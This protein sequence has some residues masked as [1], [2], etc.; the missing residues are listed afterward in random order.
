M[1]AFRTSILL[2]LALAL[3]GCGF[4]PMYATQGDG[5]GLVAE[6]STIEVSPIAERVGQVVRNGLMDRLTPD[7][8]PGTPVYRLQVT[9]SETREGFGFRPDEAITRENLRL[10]AAYSLLR[11]A[12][13]AEVLKGSARSN[14]AY[15][16]VQSD[17]ANFS[18]HQDAQR[19]TAEQVVN[20]I[21]V[22]L[23]IFLQGD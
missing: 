13:G 8:P 3:G 17:F 5:A 18:A 2:V 16:I 14:L 7:G 1:A 10:D 23:G 15:D 11:T 12:D 21:V 6:F 19:R 9:L 4:T 20:I 22:R